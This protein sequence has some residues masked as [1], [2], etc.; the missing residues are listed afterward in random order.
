MMCLFWEASIGSG[1]RA[2]SRS[3]EFDSHYLTALFQIA[4][5]LLSRV[6]ISSYLLLRVLR[7]EGKRLVRNGRAW[8]AVLDSWKPGA[9]RIEKSWILVCIDAIQHGV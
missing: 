6:K 2:T 9:L 1:K 5:R 7:R 3:A 8:A 4:V